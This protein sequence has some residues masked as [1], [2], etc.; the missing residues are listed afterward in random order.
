MSEHRPIVGALERA[1]RLGGNNHYE[2]F[3]SSR[4]EKTLKKIAIPK[5]VDQVK[6]AL[7]D[8]YFTDMLQA[9]LTI[10]D[11]DRKIAARYGNEGPSKRRLERFAEVNRGLPRSTTAWQIGTC[12]RELNIEFSSGPLALFMST[13]L[14]ELILVSAISLQLAETEGFAPS[15]ARWFLRWINQFPSLLSFSIFDEKP[16]LRSVYEEMENLDYATYGKF[17]VGMRSQVRGQDE[18][19]ERSLQRAIEESTLP[20]DA[21]ELFEKAYS[22]DTN[23]DLF[24]LRNEHWR[25]ALLIAHSDDLFTLRERHRLISGHIRSALFRWINLAPTSTAT[26]AT[27]DDPVTRNRK[28]LAVLLP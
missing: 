15:F 24:S 17:L 8:R 20:D 28:T 27:P 2:S 14:K 21:A 25:A 26:N 6:Q 4:K 3:T 18:T 10:A 12:A 7:W 1:A 16:W 13:N 5:T 11:L 19:T 9:G 22:H 23:V